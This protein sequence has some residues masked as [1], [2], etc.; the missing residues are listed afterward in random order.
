MNI[1]ISS[2]LHGN[3]PIWIKLAY[4][5][6]VFIIV[7]VYWRDWGP[8]NFL[9]LSDIAL[10]TM[11]F[12][13]WFENSL[14]SSMM[15]V[16]VLPLELFWT[17]DFI[18]KG[19]FGIASYMFDRRHPLYLRL[20]S[21]FH[22]PL[23]FSIIYMLIKFG[24]KPQAIYYQT[25]LIWILFPLTYA[26]IDRKGEN[27]NWVFGFGAKPLPKKHPIRYLIGLLLGITLLIYI[28][29]HF[30]LKHFIQY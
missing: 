24:Y 18:C 20:L 15:I 5:I 23:L 21:L 13:L 19:K 16:G 25:I 10:F 17:F 1:E 8:K 29:L 7:P 9:W 4:S 2:F 14:L 27:I 26:I 30:I 11:F 22:L 12:A 3:I 28:P 6:M